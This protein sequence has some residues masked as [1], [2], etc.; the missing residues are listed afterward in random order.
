MAVAITLIPDGQG[1]LPQEARD[2]DRLA[3]LL[4]AANNIPD[5]SN[6]PLSHWRDV[7]RVV[8]GD[9]SRIELRV[10]DG[11]TTLSDFPGNSLDAIGSAIINNIS[12]VKAHPNGWHNVEA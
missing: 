6:S 9:G 3:G 1:T 7:E 12:G 5:Q 4:E 2:H 8:H 11:D 10:G